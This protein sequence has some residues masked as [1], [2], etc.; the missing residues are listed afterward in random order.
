VF[1]ID[2]QGNVKVHPRSQLSGSGK[3][4][5]LFGAD[6][7]RQV[8]AGD[9]RAVRFERDGETFLGVAQKF[10]SI[11]WLLVSEVPEAEVYAEAR[12][13]LLMTSLIGVAVALLFLGLVVLLA[14]G[15]VRPIRQV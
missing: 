9:S 10:T 13:A 1:L 4:G 11:D 5:E 2:S 7:S 15:L 12:Q 14:R 8:L 6:A 3:L